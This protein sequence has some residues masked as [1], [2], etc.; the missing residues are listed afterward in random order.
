VIVLTF[1]KL[2]CIPERCSGAIQLF[3][4]KQYGALSSAM[5]KPDK[6]QSAFAGYGL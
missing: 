4:V 6:S 1:L 5:A 3:K 2:T